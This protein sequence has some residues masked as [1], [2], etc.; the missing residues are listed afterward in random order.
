M[1]LISSTD[2]TDKDFFN[3]LDLYLVT[4]TKEA[5]PYASKSTILQRLLY[6]C[7]NV[8]NID[9]NWH[10]SKNVIQIS[11]DNMLKID[12]IWEKLNKQEMK[13]THDEENVYKIFKNSDFI[14]VLDIQKLITILVNKNEE[15]FLVELL[16]VDGFHSN[17]K[18]YIENL[19][20]GNEGSTHV[21]FIRN[22]Y[23][24]FKDCTVKCVYYILLH[25]LMFF[26]K[27]DE[28]RQLVQNTI[29]EL[30]N[31]FDE[32]ENTFLNLNLK[33]M[34]D[35]YLDTVENIESVALLKIAQ[36]KVKNKKVKKN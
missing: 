36:L 3:A 31:N 8:L 5:H 22:I 11:P 14:H 28:I 4:I 15:L 21:H 6:E 19:K 12:T 30:K 9:L 13:I 26:A 35:L 33:K 17:L 7:S 27:D 24:N 20:I 2:V 32:N 10:Q 34:V 16:A 1:A 18:K 25:V 23:K 29:D